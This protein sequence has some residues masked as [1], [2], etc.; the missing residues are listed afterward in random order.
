VRQP[1]RLRGRRRSADLQSLAIRDV[2]GFE[3]RF[4]MTSNPV[5]SWPPPVTY[6]RTLRATLIMDK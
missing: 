1:F 5:R 3:A 4:H 6:R 2:S